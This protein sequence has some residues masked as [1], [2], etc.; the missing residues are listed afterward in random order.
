[1]NINLLLSISQIHTDLAWNTSG[2]F[3]TVSI[4]TCRSDTMFHY[5]KYTLKHFPRNSKF[6]DNCTLQIL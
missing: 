2:K 3:R 6:L 4:A 1:M 5:H